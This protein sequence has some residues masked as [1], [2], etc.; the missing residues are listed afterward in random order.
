MVQD[1]GLANEV[2]ILDVEPK[3]SRSEDTDGRGCTAYSEGT[4][5]GSPIIGV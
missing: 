5:S 4:V 1:T 2:Y 3:A